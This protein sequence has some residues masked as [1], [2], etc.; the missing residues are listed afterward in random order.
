MRQRGFVQDY[1][2]GKDL[3]KKITTVAGDA[4]AY[5]LKP[6]ER[7]VEVD[8]TLGTL[9]LSL[10]PVAECEGLEFS[11]TALTGATKTVTI[12]PYATSESYDWPGNPALNAN[13]DRVHFK[14]DGKRWWI[15][16]DMF[17]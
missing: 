12:T 11:I 7:Y 1:G 9:A 14:S 10:P 17:T 5:T 4:D 13:L 16:T 8:S 15:V 2:G 3:Y 6:Y